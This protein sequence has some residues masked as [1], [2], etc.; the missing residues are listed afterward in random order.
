MGL[1]TF[2]GF[3]VEGGA[4][5]YVS[6]FYRHPCIGLVMG[7][8]LLIRMLANCGPESFL[9]L[10]WNFTLSILSTIGYA[11]T[12]ETAN[13]FRRGQGR[14]ELCSVS[15]HVNFVFGVEFCRCYSYYLNF[16]FVLSVTDGCF[17][18]LMPPTYMQIVCLGEKGLPWT[19]GR[20][21]IN[22]F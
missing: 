13:D 18:L 11:C 1:F 3:G 9:S 15:Y 6:F 12:R 7:I 8:N 5:A 17:G 14:V 20:D 10:L 4:I 16:V 21:I 19:W 22:Y 2:L